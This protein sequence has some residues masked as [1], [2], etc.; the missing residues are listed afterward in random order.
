MTVFPRGK[1]QVDSTAQFLEWFKTPSAGQV[2]Y[3]RLRRLA[4]E[5][6]ERRKPK[7]IQ[8]T[9]ARGSMEWAAAQKK[10]S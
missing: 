8:P 4:E 7:P 3:E 1:D 10:S 2:Y 5:I 6:E 9:Y